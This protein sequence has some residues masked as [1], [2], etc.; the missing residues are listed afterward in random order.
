MNLP[1]SFCHSKPFS[2]SNS[3]RVLFINAL[4]LA[5]FAHAATARAVAMVVVAACARAQDLD[6]VSFAGTVADQNGAVVP[7]ASVTATLLSTKSS[8][9]ATTD[10][11][12]RD[13]KSVV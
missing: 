3:T 13:R 11:E 7:G 1:A 8:R 10:G 5:V 2:F 9:A 6:N 12:G 4:A